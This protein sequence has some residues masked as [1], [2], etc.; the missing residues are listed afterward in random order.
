MKKMQAHPVLQIFLWSAYNYM[1]LIKN[2]FWN[3]AGFAIPI[4]IAIPA[5]GYLARVLGVERFGLFTLA[6]AVV[7]YA[8]IFDAGLS[9]AV[10]RA[11]A[12]H[13]DQDKKLGEILG[14]STV[15]VLGL[16]IC[17]SLLLY[18][19]AKNITFYLSV[20]EAF[21]ADA[22]EGFQW[23]SFAVV[24]LLLSTIWFSYLEGESEFLKLNTLKVITGVA[25]AIMP[26]VVV[27]YQVSFKSA[28]IG[29]VLGRLFTAL[30]AYG[31]G[32]GRFR[33]DIVT[34]DMQTLKELL[35][36]GGWI[37]VSNILSPVMVYF[38]RFFISNALGA[39]SVAFY[40][41]PAEAVARML[42]IPMAI[43]KVIFPMLSAK[44]EN[45]NV[46]TDFAFKLL[47]VFSV[48]MAIFVF[49][50]A[51]EILLLWMGPDYI[52][53]SVTVLRILAVGFVFN[54]I[55]QIPFAKIQAG[56]HSKITALIH[57]AE[58]VPYVLL[59]FFLVK[60]LSLVGAAIAWSFR[61]FVDYVALD[62][63]SRQIIKVER[64]SNGLR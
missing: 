4:V 27:F 18:L 52:G 24:P 10:I 60:E 63:A 31:Y 11:V 62:L 17:A 58:I 33:K 8:S 59:M 46:Q 26:V 48:V 41:A 20:S 34:V 12:M 7:G 1:S 15:F 16:S 57:L 22:V 13:R 6:Y 37:T 43:S 61:V 21:S 9:R 36:F 45:A 38:D 25:I 23:L 19:N 53:E 2:S 29:L 3:I 28:V 39:Q 51:N 35:R 14:T 64:G 47:L 44:H 5:I 55:A 42:L 30:V 54:S 49:I 56:G 32:L 50:L 40:T